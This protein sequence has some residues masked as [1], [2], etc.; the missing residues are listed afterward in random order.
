MGLIYHAPRPS[1]GFAEVRSILN[2]VELEEKQSG[3]QIKLGCVVKRYKY[4]EDDDEEHQHLETV[5]RERRD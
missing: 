5:Q 4:R 3:E 1:F 2:D